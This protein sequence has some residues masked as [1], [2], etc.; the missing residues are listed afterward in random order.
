MALALLVQ[1]SSLVPETIET[2]LRRHEVDAI[3][4]VP[5][6]EQALPWLRER[7]VAILL[8]PVDQTP[9]VP[10]RW[11]AILRSHP[12]LLTVAVAPRQ[13]A[14]VVLTALRAGIR[15]FLVTPIV[16]EEL[17]AA[18]T[19]LRTGT[20]ERTGT[21]RGTLVAVHAAK[22]GSG[23]S[24][25]AASLAWAFAHMSGD[26]R[27]P[28]TRA[29]LAD[30]TTTGIGVRGML[31]MEPPHD[32]SRLT[33]RADGVD[34]ALLRS[35]IFDHPEQLGILAAPRDPE[36]AQPPEPTRLARILE[37]LQ[38]EYRQVIADTDHH[39]AGHTLGI[40]E[41]ANRIL[42]LTQRDLVSLRSTQRALSLFSAVGL[43]DDRVH[44][45]INRASPRDRIPSNQVSHVLG[46][47]VFAELP[48]DFAACEYAVTAGVFAAQNRRTPF[49]QAV[50]HLAARLGSPRDLAAPAAGTT[51]PAGGPMGRF[52]A[53]F[54]RR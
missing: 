45:V 24:T 29:V 18:L 2:V 44:V 10:T 41:A 22:G 23:V 47:A 26:G 38:A 25:V 48:N 7:R 52:G 50:M 49:A 34:R 28:G 51:P 3:Q 5:T 1:E 20:R 43:P 19:R 27:R 30:F 11:A 15:E 8:L 32:L 35:V 36:D 16:P 21:R 54:R 40:L 13:E 42:L 46:R 37:L 4:V 6:A 17:D 14:D 9:D 31:H 33:A 39:L 53:L 12:E